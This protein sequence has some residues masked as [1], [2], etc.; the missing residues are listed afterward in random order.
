MST[1]VCSDLHANWK[2]WTQIKNFLKPTDTLYN[3]GDTVDRGECGLEI[4]NDCLKMP[5]VIL[6]RGNHEDFIVS[7]GSEI[8]YLDIS[9]KDW[10]DVL[11]VNNLYLWTINGAKNT[12][13]AFLKLPINKRK[14]L[15]NIIEKLPTHIKYINK[16]G[17]VLF[18]SHS[19]GYRPNVKEIF[20]MKRGD[21]PMDNYIWDRSHIFEKKWYGKENEYC[22]HGHTPVKHLIDYLNPTAE[23]PISNNKIFKYCNNHK[24]DIDLGSF[25]SKTAC[26]LNLDTFETVY[27][28]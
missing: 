1:Y 12:I 3:L 28:S 5:N 23:I 14:K 15:I 26:L 11:H 8:V 9:K 27:F 4:L 21:V 10:T 13:N 7:I 18:L 20:D 25:D 16:N 6:L 22:I 17:D 2:L 19:G 24:I